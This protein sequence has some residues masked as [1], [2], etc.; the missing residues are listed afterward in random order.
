MIERIVLRKVKNAEELILDMMSTPNFILKSVDWGTIKGNH[1]SY[2][3]VNQ[4][5]ETVTNTSLDK[6]KV[7]IEGWVVAQNENEMSTLKRKLNSF[8]NPQEAIDLLYSLMGEDVEPRRDFI[9][10]NA[11]FV[12]NLDI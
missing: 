9:T 7:V 8:V 12:E 1:N 11:K 4:V 3:Y 10:N 2:K 5:G 6:R